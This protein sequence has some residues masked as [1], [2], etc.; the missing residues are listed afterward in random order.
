MPHSKDAEE[1]E[2]VWNSRD[3]AGH[4]LGEQ[5]IGLGSLCLYQEPWQLLKVQISWE[6]G[7]LDEKTF[8]SQVKPWVFLVLGEGRD[9]STTKSDP[10]C[11][12]KC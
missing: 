6:M 8:K 9:E 5:R 12:N 2:R 3:S 11:F 7:G 4:N 10:L 1:G